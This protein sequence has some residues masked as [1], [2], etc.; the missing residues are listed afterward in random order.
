MTTESAL[1][2]PERLAELAEVTKEYARFDASEP[3]GLARLPGA[4]LAVVGGALL[5]ARREVGFVLVC[6]LPAVWLAGSAMGSGRYQP[7][8]HV[9]PFSYV[10]PP[11]RWPMWALAGG[12]WSLGVV[13]FALQR[14]RVPAFPPPPGAS[15]TLASVAAAAMLATLPLVAWVLRWKVSRNDAYAAGL[16]TFYVVQYGSSGALAP[17]LLF[18][19]GLG[20][21]ALAIWEHR[22]FRKIEARMEALREAP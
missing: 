13:A 18:A 16:L 8:G 3:R 4:V 11:K 7:F 14:G 12:F 20:F 10:G 1:P 6:A 17:I 2:R 9:E 5:L 19:L 22:R 21:G 15:S